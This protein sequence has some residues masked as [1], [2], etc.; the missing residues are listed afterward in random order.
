MKPIHLR[1][2]PPPA[3]TFNH[4]AFIEF[5]CSWIKPENYLELGVRSGDTFFVVAKHC[6][7]AIG[8]DIVPSARP[9]MDNMEYHMCTTD[10]YFKNLDANERVLMV[11]IKQQVINFLFLKKY[12]NH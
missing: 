8:V 6:Q 5:I 3:E 4:V 12:L 10:E 1:N 7:K 2:V 9:L 11:G